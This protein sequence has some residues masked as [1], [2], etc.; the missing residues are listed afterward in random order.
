MI[1]HIYNTKAFDLK[2]GG[3]GR[4]GGGYSSILASLVFKNTLQ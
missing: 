3:G 4:R 1:Y 2:Y